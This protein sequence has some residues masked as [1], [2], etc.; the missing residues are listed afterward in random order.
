MTGKGQLIGEPGGKYYKTWAN[1]F[2]RY[3]YNPTSIW[4]FMKEMVKIKRYGCPILHKSDGLYLD[5]V[6]VVALRITLCNSLKTF[7]KQILMLMACS[8]RKGSE[9]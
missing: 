8:R 5:L 7:D 9:M 6:P 1:Y 2:V 3:T 4:R